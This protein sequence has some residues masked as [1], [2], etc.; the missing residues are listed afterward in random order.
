MSKTATAE[1]TK[2]PAPKGSK[3]DFDPIWETTKRSI[4]Q[5]AESL[6]EDADGLSLH[7]FDSEVDGLLQ[8]QGRHLFSQLFRMEIERKGPR[9]AH[10]HVCF[11]CDRVFNCR[12]LDHD[13]EHGECA[14]C[15]EG[16]TVHSSSRL[17]IDHIHPI[18]ALI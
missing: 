8:W 5:R 18:K 3:A 4:R 11:S 9:R 7:L 10:T 2:A 14:E 13:H 15:H 1:Q 12:C 6:N 16:V 17:D